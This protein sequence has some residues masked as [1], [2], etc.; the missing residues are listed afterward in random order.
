MRQPLVSIIIPYYNGERFIG[1]T[2]DCVSAQNYPNLEVI[3]VDDGSR[4]ESLAALDSYRGRITLIRQE[5]AGQAAARN[6]GLRA[7]QGSIIGLL[8]QDDLWP[9]DHL[10]LMVPHLMSGEYDVVRGTTVCFEVHPDGTRSSSDAQVLPVLVGSMLYTR[11]IIDQVGPFDAD[12]HEGEDV[13][14]IVRMTIEHKARLKEIPNL[15]LL[16]RKHD[17]NYS[18]VQPR[19]AARGTFNSIRKKLKRAREDKDV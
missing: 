7:A 13:D 2:L 16:H 18:I 1:E 12:L 10:A 5:N 19:F 3:V 15:A 14:W 4:P 6:A 11:A 9:S 17:T 8:D